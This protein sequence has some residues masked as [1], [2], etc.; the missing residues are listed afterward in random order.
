MASDNAD[1][2]FWNK[3]IGTVLLVGLITIGPGFVADLLV[4]PE[5]LAEHAY[6]IAAPETSSGAVAAPTAAAAGPESVGALLAAADPIAGRKLSK[7]CGGCHS[8]DNGGPNKIGPNLWDTVGREVASVGGFK[9]SDALG[10]IGGAWDYEAL[11]R[12]LFKPKRFAPGTKMSF[13]G[14]KKADER[15]NL[16]AWMRTLSDSPRPLP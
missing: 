3:I 16:I 1:P 10:G 9:Y 13:A 5:H 8:F 14:L 7:K 15:A 6:M 4:A 2:L 11:N 12:F